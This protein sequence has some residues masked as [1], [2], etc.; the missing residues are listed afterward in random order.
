MKSGTFTDIV[1]SNYND[2]KS[3]FSSRSYNISIQFDEDLFNDAFI[4]C[5]NKFKDEIITYDTVIKYFW[6]VYVNT[7]KSDIIKSKKLETEPLDEEIHDCIDNTY[8]ELYDSDYAIDVYNTIMNAIT[9][10]YGEDEMLIY[11]LY[12]YHD[13]TVDD[14]KRAGYDCQN[15]DKRIK[16]IHRFV[17]IYSKKHLSK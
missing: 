2:I 5:T 6:T 1:A 4:K 15:L 16:A 14:I 12:K 11:S 9:V 13:W 8:N 3:I 7:V 10:K 17:K